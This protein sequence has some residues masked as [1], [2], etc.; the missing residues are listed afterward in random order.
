MHGTINILNA[1]IAYFAMAAKEWLNDLAP[2]NNKV[3]VNTSTFK[4]LKL[5]SSAMEIIKKSREISG[6]IKHRCDTI[7]AVVIYQ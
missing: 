1:V 5:G 2:R 7:Y 6:I 3:C 4:G